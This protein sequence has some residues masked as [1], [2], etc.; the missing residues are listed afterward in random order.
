MNVKQMKIVRLLQLDDG[1]AELV[2]VRQV[3]RVS[4]GERKPEPLVGEVRLEQ[5]HQSSAFFEARHRLSIPVSALLVPCVCRVPRVPRVL[6]GDG[7]HLAGK[8][9]GR[10]GGISQQ[11]PNAWQVE[12]DEL[13]LAHP[14]SVVAPILA[15]VV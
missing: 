7:G 3:L 4:A 6:S 1:F 8:E 13:L 14:R 2:A 10:E 5:L 12:G 15:A 9:V 11:Q